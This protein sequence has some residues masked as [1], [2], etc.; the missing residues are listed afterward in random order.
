MWP[1]RVILLL[2]V[3]VSIALQTSPVSIIFTV[4]PCVYVYRPSP[5][6]VWARDHRGPAALHP[7]PPPQLPQEAAAP[8]EDD[9]AHQPECGHAPP[10]PRHRHSNTGEAQNWWDNP[11]NFLLAD[12]WHVFFLLLL[13]P[14]SLIFFFFV[15]LI[16]DGSHIFRLRPGQRW[17]VWFGRAVGY[18]IGVISN[19]SSTKH[20]LG[21][22]VPA[23]RYQWPYTVPAHCTGT[24]MNSICILSA[25]NNNN[26]FIYMDK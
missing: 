18:Q 15:V 9:V 21:P 6:S 5:A 22:R 23:Q 1:Q 25:Y 26:N 16:P 19:G 8:H 17:G 11:Y 10:P 7:P 14:V 2:F 20:P 4:W 12:Q 13:L 24:A 3:S